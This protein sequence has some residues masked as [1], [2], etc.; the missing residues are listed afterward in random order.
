MKEI[1]DSQYIIS[2]QNKT[3]LS[4]SVLTSILSGTR[5]MVVEVQALVVQ[6]GYQ[7]SKRTFVGV[8]SHRAHLM[9]AID[10]YFSLKLPFK[11]IFISMVGG[12]KTQRPDIDLSIVAILS[13]YFVCPLPKQLVILGEVGLTGEILPI[14]HLDRYISSMELLG[15]TECIIPK[16]NKNEWPKNNKIKPLYVENIFDAYK[17]FKEKSLEKQSIPNEESKIKSGHG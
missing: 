5:G 11:D 9:I 14:S 3:P 2:D 12:L 8:D 13:S 6:A 16:L 4:G 17:I 7:Q 10:K 15:I 1:K